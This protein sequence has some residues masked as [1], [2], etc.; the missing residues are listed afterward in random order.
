[1][2]EIQCRGVWRIGPLHQTGSRYVE[3]RVAALTVDRW[4][5]DVP[6]RELDL[7][8]EVMPDGMARAFGY[9]KRGFAPYNILVL[10]IIIP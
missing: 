7:P 9:P 3:A 2:R 5:D 4:R 1:M 6:A 10:V 8:T